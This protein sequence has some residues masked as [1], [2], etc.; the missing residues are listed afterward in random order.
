MQ[1]S[2]AP[3]AK[4]STAGDLENSDAASLLWNSSGDMKAANRVSIR[5]EEREI[6]EER[7][8]VKS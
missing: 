2:V 8:E 3:S 5:E 4:M 6:V 7:C 1:N